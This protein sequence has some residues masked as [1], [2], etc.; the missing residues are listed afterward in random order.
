MNENIQILK[1]ITP[2][3]GLFFALSAT[4]LRDFVVIQDNT[5]DLD[6]TAEQI[7]AKL[8]ATTE[9]YLEAINDNVP[10]VSPPSRESC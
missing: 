4:G 3:E 6:L 9:E 7:A 10:K 8:G 2:A 1:Q 5:P